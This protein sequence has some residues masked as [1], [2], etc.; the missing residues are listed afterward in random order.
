MVQLEM[1]DGRFA[2]AKIWQIK[3]IDLHPD[4]NPRVYDVRH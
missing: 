2:T 3:W 1:R 4:S